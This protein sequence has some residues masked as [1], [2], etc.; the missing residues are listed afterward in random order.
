[1]LTQVFF[2]VLSWTDFSSARNAH[3][4]LFLET[5]FIQKL[6]FDGA[7][8]GQRRGFVAFLRGGFFMKKRFS[9]HISSSEKLKYNFNFLLRERICRT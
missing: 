9:L 2:G 5:L 6:G 7:T 1:M 8:R 4:N 3:R